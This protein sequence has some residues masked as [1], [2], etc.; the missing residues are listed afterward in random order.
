M[1]SERRWI[2]KSSSSP[3]LI[4]ALMSC[5]QP[6]WTHTSHRHARQAQTI[7]SSIG[8]L[9]EMKKVDYWGSHRKKSRKAKN[10][11]RLC[12]FSTSLLLLC[13]SLLIK[14]QVCACYLESNIGLLQAR[15]Q[16]L[17]S[18]N[19]PLLSQ[20]SDRLQHTLMTAVQVTDTH[21]PIQGLIQKSRDI[22]TFCCFYCQLMPK[23]LGSFLTF[24]HMQMYFL[25]SI[26][27]CKILI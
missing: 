10:T 24:E 6:P 20:R 11:L 27:I 4:R 23:L 19:V 16:G 18:L 22:Y 12:N 2:L 1:S 9:V 25:R 7:Y 17:E 14:T 13:S 26:C 3:L 8:F 5:I 21:F 15:Q